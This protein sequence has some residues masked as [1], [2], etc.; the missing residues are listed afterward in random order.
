MCNEIWEEE[1]Q[2]H[3]RD[4]DVWIDEDEIWLALPQE[5]IPRQGMNMIRGF[6]HEGSR[7]TQFSA[8]TQYSL[9]LMKAVPDFHV[10]S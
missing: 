6:L 10:L 2:P 4:H 5:P 8:S 1:E 3:S 7:M 9:L